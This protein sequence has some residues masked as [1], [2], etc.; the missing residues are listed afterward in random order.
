MLL[1]TTTSALAEDSPLLDRIIGSLP[2]AQSATALDPVHEVQILYVQIG[3]DK[4]GPTFTEH[5]WHLDP[6]RYFYPASTVKLP[7][8]LFAL[9]KLAALKVAGLHRDTTMLTDADQ[10]WQTSRL[11]DPSARSGMPS[12]AH[13]LRKI[14]LVSDNASYNRL[15][16]FVGSEI[17][18]RRSDALGLKGT[19]IFHRLG[20]GHDRD[21]DRVGNPI[22]FVDEQGRLM[23]SQAG[24]IAPEI[25]RP[26][27]KV[28]KGLGY[29]RNGVLVEEPMDFSDLNSFP[30][31][32]QHRVL[33]DL[34]Y[35]RADG[36]RLDAGDRDF[37]RKTMGQYPRENEDVI[38]DQIRTKS[39]LYVKNF[40]RWKTTPIRDSL[41]CY[42]KSGRAYGYLTDN[43]YIVDQRHKIAFFLAATIHVNANRIYNDDLYEYETVGEPFMAELGKAIYHFERERSR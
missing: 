12:V 8:A 17:I 1:P 11:L 23:H 41:R 38:D 27:K 28:R 25:Y 7:V 29:L 22:R 36:L 35:P 6:D 26:G 4:T 19:H 40:L 5:S 14:F 31:P 16:E 34:F 18:R 43:A 32:D 42:N 24:S 33:R 30:L 15:Y 20:I 3:R 10:P 9:E 37:V 39:D 13:D 21:H 2:A